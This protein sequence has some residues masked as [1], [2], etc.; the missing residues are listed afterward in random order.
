MKNSLS[1]LL[2]AVVVVVQL[3]VPTLIVAGD[4]DQPCLGPSVFMKRC[5]PDARLWIAPRTT[6]AVNLE[7]TD[8]FNRTVLDFIGAADRHAAL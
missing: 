8:W 7:E 2:F 6:H 5:I 3:S 4:D 1:I